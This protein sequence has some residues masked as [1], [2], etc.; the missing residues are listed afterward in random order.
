MKGDGCW[1]WKNRVF[2]T[3]FRFFSAAIFMPC[4]MNVWMLLKQGKCHFSAVGR[5]FF[6]PDSPQNCFFLIAIV[7]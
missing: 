5:D 2:H 4:K 3:L 6:F 7:L 1:L